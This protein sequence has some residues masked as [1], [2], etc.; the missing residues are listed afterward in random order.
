MLGWILNLALGGG[1]TTAAADEGLGVSGPIDSGAVNVRGL[2]LAAGQNVEGL[3]IDTLS[4]SGTI[5]DNAT[6]VSGPIDSTGQNLEGL[7]R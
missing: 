4:V 3:I 7:I 5:N 1:A 6:S 2:I